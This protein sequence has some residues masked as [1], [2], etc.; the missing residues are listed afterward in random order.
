MKVN[1][2]VTDVETLLPEGEFIYS[3]TDHKG[4]ITEANEAFCRISA[5]TREDMIGKS[6]NIVRHP[7]VPPAAFE[8]LWRD[9]KQGRPWRGI[10]KN[11]RKDGGFYWVVANVSP[12]RENG[13]VIGYQSVRSRPSR[14]E[15]SSASAAYARIAEG[16]RTIYIEHGRIV[17]RRPAIIDTF[18]SLR[19]QMTMAGVAGV[20][21][22]TIL[23][24]MT[25]GL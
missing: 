8:D 4:V 10:V 15:I 12:V 5:Y 20:L 11:R 7:D 2:P 19:S 9:L 1:L 25:I 24:A 14:K 17:R 13:Q 6:H 22:S 18:L 3:R 21:P 16:D 23:L